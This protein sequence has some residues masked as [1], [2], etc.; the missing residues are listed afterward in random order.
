[1]HTQKVLAI[2]SWDLQHV[3]PFSDVELHHSFCELS[4]SDLDTLS[5]SILKTILIDNPGNKAKKDGKDEGK[6]NHKGESVL[7]VVNSKFWLQW[8]RE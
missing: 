2:H 3:Q 1:M 7:L 4:Q 5:P 8:F 6:K